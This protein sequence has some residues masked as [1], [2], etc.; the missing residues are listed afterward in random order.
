MA[1]QSLFNPNFNP[2]KQRFID[3][4]VMNENKEFTYALVYLKQYFPD[5]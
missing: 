3:L 2:E 4:H 5:Y 1:E